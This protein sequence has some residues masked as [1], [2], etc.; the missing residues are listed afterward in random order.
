[1]KTPWNV[2]AKKIKTVPR[3]IHADNERLSLL[4]CEPLLQKDQLFSTTPLCKQITPNGLCLASLHREV[5]TLA[6]NTS[7]S[8]KEPVLLESS[9]P[10]EGVLFVSCTN[11]Q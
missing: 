9:L 7:K 6:G 10:K 4:G 1:M 5:V 11:N 3:L 2:Q 8:R